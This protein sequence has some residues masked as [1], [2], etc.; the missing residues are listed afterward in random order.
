[1]LSARWKHISLIVGLD[2]F[3]YLCSFSHFL[4]LL[5]S[6][7]LRILEDDYLPLTLDDVT[8][9]RAAPLL[10]TISLDICETVVLQLPLR[11]L[12]HVEL[13]G[14]SN[15][16]DAVSFLSGCPNLQSLAAKNFHDNS[17]GT[18]A[19][20]SSTSLLYLSINCVDSQLR[21]RIR[22]PALEELHVHDLGSRSMFWVFDFIEQLHCQRLKRLYLHA[23][24][25][26]CPPILRSL[27]A[28]MEMIPSVEEVHIV[29]QRRPSLYLGR[30]EPIELDVVFG[31]TMK[32]IED[33]SFSEIGDK[34][35]NL[36]L[37]RIDS[38]QDAWRHDIVDF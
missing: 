23:V 28:T 24:L 38:V 36:R 12:I 26:F 34:M 19:E 3:R 4:P 8:T 20:V 22:T 37:L 5:E 2:F 14:E 16:N 7:A 15:L 10:H 17:S 33:G 6:A 31:D 21:S 18:S 32:Y 11:Q 29:L 30:R 25:E 9:F 1:M 13:K 35:P 27:R